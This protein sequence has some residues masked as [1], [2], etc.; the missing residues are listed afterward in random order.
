MSQAAFALAEGTNE[1]YLQVALKYAK[2]ATESQPS[3]AQVKTHFLTVRTMHDTVIEAN[4]QEKE[5]A[6]A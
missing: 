6:K 5:Q 1:A 3:N 4:R 2:Q